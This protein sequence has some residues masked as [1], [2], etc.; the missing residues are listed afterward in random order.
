L[1]NSLIAELISAPEGTRWYEI[2]VAIR[3][4]ALF[5]YDMLS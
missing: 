4:G 2:G 5:R 1:K 3:R